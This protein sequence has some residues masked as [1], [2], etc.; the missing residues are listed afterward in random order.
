MPLGAGVPKSQQFTLY[1]DYVQRSGVNK[2]V[3][4]LMQDLVIMQPE[5]PVSFMIDFLKGRLPPPPPDPERVMMLE[6]L[7]EACDDDGSGALSLNEFAQLFERVD[8]NT[9]EMFAEVDM[10]VSD[11]K[12]TQKEFVTFHLQK[13]SALSDDTFKLIVAQLTERAEDVDVIDDEAAVVIEGELVF[14]EASPTKAS[15]ALPAR[16]EFLMAKV[17]KGHVIT[18]DER[19]ELERAQAGEKVAS[20]KILSGRELGALKSSSMSRE[21]MLEDLF[22]ACDDDGSGALSLNEFSQVRRARAHAWPSQD[23]PN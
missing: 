16:E 2:L 13:F 18:S 10:D 22:Q 11:G 14:V 1:H 17:A 15:T 21:M 19:L 3:A 20:G 12:L 23:M 9:R 4:D 6:E 5:E 8:E 7:F